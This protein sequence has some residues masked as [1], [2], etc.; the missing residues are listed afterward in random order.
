MDVSF[1]LP[2]LLRAAIVCLATMALSA[3]TFA[4]G[5]YL[6]RRYESEI[7]L[8]LGQGDELAPENVNIQEI[9]AQLIIDMFNAAPPPR[10]G[11][12]DTNIHRPVQRSVLD[13]AVETI[14]YTLGP[15]DI[16]SIIVWDHPELTTPAGTYRTAEQAGTVVAE[17]GTI[18]FPYAGVIQVAGLTTRQVRDILASKLTK[19]IEKIQLDVRMAQF[20]SKRV[21]VVGEVTKPGTQE[22]TDIPMTI[23]EAVNRAGG[24]T[25]EADYSRV[26]LTR[27]GTTHRVDI[28]SMY[29]QGDTE[30]NALLEPGDIVN[31]SD[32]SYNK[33][34]V[35]GEVN[36][37][38]SLIMNK[39]R[40]TLAEALS[41]AGYINQ[42]KA[43]P[44]WIYVMRGD[45]KTP[46][47]FHL[48][49]RSP[50]AML[51]ADRF[52]LHPRDIV[53]VDT[54][55]VVRWNRVVTNILPTLNMLNITSGTRYPLF[56]GRQ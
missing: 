15:G 40:S 24:F 25:T 10:V 13:P 50:D 36:K 33:I 35:L 17:D 20:R 30:Q 6:S 16:I 48:N 47:L 7:K 51:L 21:Y 26:L 8:P 29:E 4:P 11:H 45:S 34:F 14:N 9:T 37:P 5:N 28:Q 22:I 31:V 38:G 43:N 12:S 44:R 18:F 42:D 19:Y 27:R 3:C 52:P 46:E 56:G 41:D 55:E 54:A 23:L 39:K 2:R 53:Y 49:G 32:R 1:L